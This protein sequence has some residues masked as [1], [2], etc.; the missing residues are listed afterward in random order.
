MS[1]EMTSERSE[2]KLIQSVI[3]VGQKRLQP[4]YCKSCGMFYS[5]V[6]R[7]DLME[8]EKFHARRTR[9]LRFARSSWKKVDIV[10]KGLE[11]TV[12][13]VYA[14]DPKYM[15]NKVDDICKLVDGELGI[16]DPNGLRSSSW[17]QAFIYV[18]DSR[19][20]EVAGI[21]LV[22]SITKGY[23]M[24]RDGCVSTD[25]EEAEVGINRIWVAPKQR[26]CGI[27]T[28]LLNAVKNNYFMGQSLSASLLAF[29]DPTEQGAALA[30]R[31]F[32]RSDFL[33]YSANELLS[34]P[35][36]P[37]AMQCL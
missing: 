1:L 34:Q 17:R 32:G 25:A 30:S 36:A 5:P 33:T 19:S 37:P 4:V 27:A 6:V 24:L 7:N 10:L 31:Y 15:T 18:P 13:R 29:S 21:C 35:E 8:H 22:E 20:P 3:D 11:G 26:R 2:G 12:Y 14:N 23:R 16:A 9:T 28:M